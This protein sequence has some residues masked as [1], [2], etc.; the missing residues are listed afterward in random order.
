MAMSYAAQADLEIRF[1]LDELIQLTDRAT[2]PSGEI[3]ED[4]VSRALMDA[5]NL[6]NSF[7]GARYL[8]PLTPVPD[9]ILQ[10]ACDIARYSLHADHVPE[11]VKDRYMAALG[12]LKMIAA[13]SA[14]LGSAPIA[15]PPTSSTDGPSWS[16]PGSIFSRDALRD[17]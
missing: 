1:G 13:G 6:I 2:P 10:I 9:L 5:D 4:V 8:V 3:D 12:H 16:S 7:V 15:T 11:A 14:V 17:F